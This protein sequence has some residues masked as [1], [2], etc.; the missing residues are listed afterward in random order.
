MLISYM[1]FQV[2]KSI[3]N[4]ENF[5]QVSDITDIEINQSQSVQ[6]DGVD[7]LIC[8]TETGIYAVEDK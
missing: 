5:I 2:N 8:H 6:V 4:G 3:N 7:I 1:G